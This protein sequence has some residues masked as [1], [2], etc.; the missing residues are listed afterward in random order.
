MQPEPGILSPVNCAT[1]EKQNVNGLRSC[2]IPRV[3]PARGAASRVKIPV[4]VQSG[5]VGCCQ[6]LGSGLSARFLAGVTGRWL[7]S[8]MAVSAGS[9]GSLHPLFDSTSGSCSSL[10][11][12]TAPEIK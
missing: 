6:L 11:H 10:T 12:S 9:S 8:A 3:V 5:P 1:N 2:S 7:L 4:R